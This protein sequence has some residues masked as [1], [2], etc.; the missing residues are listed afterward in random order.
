M[1]HDLPVNFHII[2]R[3]CCCLH[4]FIPVRFKYI[5]QLTI[6]FKHHELNILKSSPAILLKCFLLLF[7]T[8]TRTSVS[9]ST[10]PSSAKPCHYL[11]HFRILRKHAKKRMLTHPGILCCR[12]RNYNALLLAMIHDRDFFFSFE[13]LKNISHFIS[14]ISN[15]CFNGISLPCI[16]IYGY[17]G[18]QELTFFSE[19]HE[20]RTPI[21]EPRPFYSAIIRSTT[22]DTSFLSSA[23]RCS[24]S[25]SNRRETPPCGSAMSSRPMNQGGPGSGQY[26][27]CFSQGNSA[28]IT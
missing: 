23:S 12:R 21:P 8:Q 22:D 16:C 4:L 15:G 27:P 2:S 18:T 13:R 3:A 6:Y 5:D 7:Y 20:P 28:T 1:R 25:A 9:N 19:N 11:M 14:Q 17:I 10:I 26:Y 24:E